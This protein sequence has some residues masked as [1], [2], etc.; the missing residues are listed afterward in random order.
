MLVDG[1]ADRDGSSAP[2]EPDPAHPAVGVLQGRLDRLCA[3]SVSEV[4]VDGAGI[5][6]MAGVE[7]GRAGARDQ[8][9]AT[10]PLARRL[11]ELQLTV[12]EGPCLDAY[13]DGLPVLAG[14]L[15][16]DP[17]R[18]LGF[19][20]EAIEA[21][22]AA[23]FSLPLQ[24]GVVRFGTLD[25]HR[26]TTGPLS[27][28]QL[29]DAL[30]LATLATETLL[31]PAGP[32]DGDGTDDAPEVGWLLP[33]VHADV[34]VASGMISARARIDV[35]VALLRL[36]AFAFARGEPLHQVARRIIDRDLVLDEIRD[37]REPGAPGEQRDHDPTQGPLAPDPE[38]D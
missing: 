22:A 25:L 31:E 35:G 5:T 38:N 14:D 18:W 6:V 34:H 10:G 33:D 32:P 16:A 9:A 8:L 2:P 36:R 12:G 30:V 28:E 29:A 37:G 3:V 21:G 26:T 11:E 17:T 24:I 19:G 23:L 15:V 7:A 4:G 13:R 27:R 1:S 20:P